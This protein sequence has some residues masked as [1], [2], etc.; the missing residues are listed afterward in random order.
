[1]CDEQLSKALED[2]DNNNKDDDNADNDEG[3]VE[4]RVSESLEKSDEVR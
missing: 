3:G 4:E 2:K 1:M